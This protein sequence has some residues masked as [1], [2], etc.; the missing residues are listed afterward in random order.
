[1]SAETYRFKVHLKLIFDD[2][3]E[4]SNFLNWK[5][6]MKSGLPDKPGNG[7]IC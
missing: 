1:M 6:K 3:V 2:L 5:D 4:F 7:K